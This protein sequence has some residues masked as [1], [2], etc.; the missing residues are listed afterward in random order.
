MP[1]RPGK[2]RTLLPEE[3]QEEEQQS[4]PSG[5]RT[6]SHSPGKLRRRPRWQQGI[7]IID[8]RRHACP[9][10]SLTHALAA[11]AGLLPLGPSSLRQRP[12]CRAC[13]L[14]QLLPFASPA[15]RPWTPKRAQGSH[16]PLNAHWEPLE[17]SQTRRIFPVQSRACLQEFSRSAEGEVRNR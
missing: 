12:L 16:H 13:C 15:P 3:R 9:A 2:L 1:P 5:P 10:E 6:P 7:S 8:R 11:A 4:S 17:E 14:C